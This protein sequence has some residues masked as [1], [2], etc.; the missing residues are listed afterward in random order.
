MWFGMTTRL[1]TLISFIEGVPDGGGSF[2]EPLKNLSGNAGTSSRPA[3]AVSG[4]SVHVV[5]D[6]D[7]SG[8][9]EMLYRNL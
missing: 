9:F 8:N 3:I 4:N 7:T 6:D 5:W 1:Q 2:T